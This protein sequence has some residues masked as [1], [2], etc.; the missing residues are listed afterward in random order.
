MP[1]ETLSSTTGS[2]EEEG[3]T[4]STGDSDATGPGTGS[5]STAAGEASTDATG[6]GGVDNG[7]PGCGV[8][9]S[10]DWLE[11][12]DSAFGGTA[13][14][15]EVDA[16]GLTRQYLIEIPPE[17]D[18]GRAYP[19]IYSMHGAGHIM[20]EAHS[21][22][23]AALWDDQAIAIYPQGI[24]DLWAVGGDDRDVLFFSSVLQQVGTELCIDLERIFVMGWSQ[25]GG[26][27]H[28]LAC[29]RA[30]LVAGSGPAAGFLPPVMEDCGPTAQFIVHGVNDN[31]ML[32]RDS[33]DAWL[34]ING[35]A[36]ES[37]ELDGY[38]CVLYDRCAAPVVYCEHDGG[39]DKALTQGLDVP[40]MAFFMER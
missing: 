10:D 4:G 1:G 13:F 35:C 3:S 23:V 40:M 26:M 27:A 14:R 25:G 9:P 2:A 5:G 34:E 39:H 7:S 20:D 19:V 32:G 22:H 38:P 21:E 24:D 8:T 33:R 15:G 29:E 28:R 36:D 11:T 17:Y 16:A 12:V 37:V 31:P 18:A 30:D 6:T